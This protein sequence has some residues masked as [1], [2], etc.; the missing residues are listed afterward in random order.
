MSK[1]ISDAQSAKERLWTE[2]DFGSGTIKSIRYND[3]HNRYTPDDDPRSI[4]VYASIEVEFD[5]DV[6]ATIPCTINAAKEYEIGQ[7]VTLSLDAD[8]E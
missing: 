1:G 4:P 8:D 2:S 7:K 5:D 3:R 6:C